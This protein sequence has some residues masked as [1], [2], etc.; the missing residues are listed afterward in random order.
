MMSVTDETEVARAKR[1]WP[2]EYKLRILTEIDQA[3][4]RGQV[5]RSAAARGCSRA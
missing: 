1:S 3:S 5:G 4:E 2:A